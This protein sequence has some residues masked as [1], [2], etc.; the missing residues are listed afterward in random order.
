MADRN[1]A[2]LEKSALFQSL[3]TTERTKL[4]ALA[5]LRKF[6]AGEPIFQMGDPGASMMGILVGTVRISRPSPNGKDVILADLPAGELFGEIAML[7]GGG[8]SAEA[9][10]LT[11]VELLVIDRRD[12]M[13]VLSS[14]P[15]ACL[16]LLSHVC[17]LL[18][19]SD[20]RMHDIAFADLAAR[21]AKAI[22]RRI[23]AKSAA[24]SKLSL[25][26]SELARIAVGSREAVNRQL[27][28]WQKKG[29]V[30]LRDGWIVVLAPGALRAAAGSAD[31]DPTD[32]E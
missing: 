16:K 22:L 4:A 2:G 5:H 32:A 23:P 31:T 25:S 18:R 29:V 9:T 14:H 27:A 17:G 20:D 24:N 21:L 15:E 8:R 1:L 12:V 6:S 28:E 11:N 3:D 26:Q 30:E 10:A 13:S 7:D 19:A